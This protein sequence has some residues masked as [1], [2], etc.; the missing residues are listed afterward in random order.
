LSNAF[1]YGGFSIPRRITIIDE[2]TTTVK[3]IDQTVPATPRI[4]ASV[5]DAKSK[6]FYIRWL[7][8]SNGGSDVEKLNVT[9]LEYGNG[10][11]E[12]TFS[13][14]SFKK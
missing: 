12:R 14:G 9:F 3:P 13:K 4:L 11:I 7:Y 10:L 2:D 1:G 8:S 5:Y 6:S